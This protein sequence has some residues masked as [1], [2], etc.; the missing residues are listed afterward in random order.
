MTRDIK[1][2]IDPSERR[3]TIYLPSNATGEEREEAAHLFLDRI[4]DGVDL[5]GERR[6]EEITQPTLVKRGQDS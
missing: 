3:D 1:T 4:V 2:I 5:S 6:L